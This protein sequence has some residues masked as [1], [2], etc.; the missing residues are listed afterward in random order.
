MRTARYSA[1]RGRLLPPAR[2]PC[3][4]GRRRGGTVTGLLDVGLR[5]PLHQA[6]IDLLEELRVED[7]LG[8]ELLLDA[9]ERVEEVDEVVHALDDVGGHLHAVDVVGHDLLGKIPVE[10]HLARDDLDRRVAVVVDGLRRLARGSQ[11]GLE[12][13]GILLQHLAAGHDAGVHLQP[14]DGPLLAGNAALAAR[15]VQLAARL[16]HGAERPRRPRGHRVDVALGERGDGVGRREVHELDLAEVDA[17]GLAEA[18]DRHGDRGALRHPDLELLE[19]LRRLHDLL[20]LLAEDHLLYPADV[21][22]R[23]DVVDLLAG[24]GDGHDHRGGRRAEVDVAGAPHARQVG[25]RD[26]PADVD[27]EAFLLEVAEL[28]GDGELRRHLRIAHEPR[29]DLAHLRLLG[30]GVGGGAERDES[31]QHGDQDTHERAPFIYFAVH[32]VCSRQRNKRRSAASRDALTMDPRSPSTRAPMTIW[33]GRKNVRPSMIRWPS[34]ASAPMNSAPTMTNSARA[35][36][37]LSATMIPGSA[38]GTITRR[39]RSTWPAPR[40]AA[41]RSSVTS[42]RSTAAAIATNIGKNVV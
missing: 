25:A 23:R 18:L 12:R 36:P 31:G 8:R 29:V 21:A 22:L 39:M 37:S 6:R 26:V 13:V 33:A 34:P 14:V 30:E 5:L 11:H 41:A 16:L 40:L 32:M 27:L 1:S 15:E 35:K 9:V 24:R 28:I 4:R 17:I 20:R 2:R 42:T 7:L 38:A 10:L 19:V 3:A